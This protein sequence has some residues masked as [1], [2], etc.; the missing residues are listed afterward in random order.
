M[1]LINDYLKKT[2]AEAPIQDKTG[3]V[4]PALKSSAKTRDVASS[5]RTAAVLAVVIIA[6]MVYVALH[7]TS[8]KM[9]VP[10]DLLRQSPE[11]EGT[12]A[13]PAPLPPVEK[14]APT[15]LVSSEP[16]DVSAAVTLPKERSAPAEPHAPAAPPRQQPPAP[17]TQEVRLAPP[18]AA[19]AADAHIPHSPA[20]AEKP[21]PSEGVPSFPQVLA[22]SVEADRD[23]YYQVGL[24]AQKQG[25]Y[26][27]AEKHYRRVLAAHP[28]HLEALT[29]L[30]AVYILQ[31]NYTEARATLDTIL[32]VS[33]RNTKALVNL[34][35]IN[36]KTGQPEAAE[37]RFLEAL[38]IDPREETALTNLAYL[39]KE[40]NDAGQLEHYYTRLLEVAPDNVEVMFAYASFLEQAS[41]FSEAG[42]LYQKCLD[43]DAVKN[44]RTLVQQV[45][46]RI[47]LL[48]SYAQRR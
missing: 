9:T 6:G 26:R 24:M 7:S 45:T 28:A 20:S 5:V 13:P 29:N 10:P 47:A 17:A 34:G 41:R 36:L 18:G 2:Q 40:K 43:L 32:R 48:R 23:H 33:P 15:V 42:S 38:S 46:D 31:N 27:E 44:N 37:R 30:A 39:A 11:I 3:D 19:S 4:P 35:I 8:K 1:S 16:A 12:T 21:L 14:A 25:D 22:R